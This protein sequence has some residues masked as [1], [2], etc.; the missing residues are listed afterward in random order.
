MMLTINIDKNMEKDLQLGVEEATKL[1][2]EE[3]QE[4][5]D[6]TSHVDV[7]SDPGHYVIYWEMSGDVSD[8]VLQECCK[9]LDR[10]FVDIGYVSSRKA[11]TIGPLELHILE[12]GTFRKI[13]E[14]YLGIGAALSQFKT[15]RC[16]GPTNNKVLQ[17]LD[18]NVAKTYFSTAF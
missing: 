9:C 3:K 7:S 8:E 5:I 6:F 14:H 10:L 15:S 4:V 1:V 2:A 18:D 17:I 12:K 13:L 11:N 16:V